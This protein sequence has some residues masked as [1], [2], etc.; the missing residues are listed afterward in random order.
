MV[1]VLDM[2]QQ[3]RSSEPI[4]PVNMLKMNFCALISVGA[5][6][7][8]YKLTLKR[9]STHHLKKDS[10]G[11]VEF[12]VMIRLRSFCPM[13]SVDCFTNFLVSA[14]FEIFIGEQ[15]TWDKVNN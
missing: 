7:C 9:N 2:A 4:D 3:Q 5:H 6:R 10:L 15:T 13:V 11:L 14:T 8:C 12:E 1:I